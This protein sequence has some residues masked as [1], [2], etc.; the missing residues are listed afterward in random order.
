MAGRL[1]AFISSTMTD[2]RNERRSV[3]RALEAA[4]IQPLNAET[5]SPDGGRSWDTICAAIDDC[6]LFILLQGESY[7]YIPQTG[8]GAGR[9]ISV[10]HMEYERA[11]EKGLVVL[12]F[13]KRPPLAP[14]RGEDDARR[15][16]AF[17]EAVGSWETGAF[18]RQFDLA[19]DLGD[20]VRDAIMDL[21]ESSFL[22]TLTRERD[23]ALTAA[24][25]AAVGMARSAGPEDGAA[26]LSA[27][28]WPL[29]AGLARGLLPMLPGGTTV[30]GILDA[31]RWSVPTPSSIAAARAAVDTARAAGFDPQQAVLLAGAGMSLRAGYPGI[32]VLWRLLLDALAARH[33][34]SV[35]GT[36]RDFHDVLTVAEH[37]LGR[38]AVVERLCQAMSPP[39]SVS[40]TLAHLIAVRRTPVIFTTNYDDLFE[41]A[42]DQQGLTP[43]IL[44]PL[45]DGYGKT[46]PARPGGDGPVIFKIDGSV[47][48]PSTLVLTQDDLRRAA[49]ATW[50]WERVAQSIRGRWMVVAG[51]ALRDPSAQRL[52]GLRAAPAGG[53]M[54]GPSLDRITLRLFDLT[55]VDI[56]ADSFMA[57]ISSDDHGSGLQG[58]EGSG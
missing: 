25:G 7:G 58:S 14:V 19:E 40:P 57:M 13:Q 6:H 10:T 47:T 28:A 11:R 38:D 45:D 29:L 16:D 35:M 39:Q 9:G 30:A 15:R 48:A 26:R 31:M 4:N 42:C 27:A 56:D 37:D 20:A 41:R 1:R 51:H 32:Q 12:P 21:Y 49:G 24:H 5:M 52:M 34:G 2:L 55:P 17:R 36:H 43:I 8:P 44:T 23:T 46:W 3:V 18:V 54:V 22:R 53:L 33:G 50:F